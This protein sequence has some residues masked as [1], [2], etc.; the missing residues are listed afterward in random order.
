MHSI[1]M[2]FKTIYILV[3][4]ALHYGMLHILCA[5]LVLGGRQNL[6]C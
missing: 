4:F 3:K 2:F 6:Q 1:L 5:T